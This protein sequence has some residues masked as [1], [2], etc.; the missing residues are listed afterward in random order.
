M[1]KFIVFVSAA[2]LTASLFGMAKAP[3]DTTASDAKQVV[4]E[5]CCGSADC[6]KEGTGGCDKAA[7]SCGAKKA[8]C[9]ACPLSK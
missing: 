3:E 9:E 7:S 1:K 4:K 2:A 8:A 6:S 5:A